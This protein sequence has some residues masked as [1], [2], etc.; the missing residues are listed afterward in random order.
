MKGLLRQSGR[1]KTSEEPEQ[2]DVWVHAGHE[3]CAWPRG[4][5]AIVLATLRAVAYRLT[6]AIK[7]T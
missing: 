1:P 7:Q 2:L 3:V 4:W 5:V 6:T